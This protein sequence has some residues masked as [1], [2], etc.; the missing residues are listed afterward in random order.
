MRILAVIKPESVDKIARLRGIEELF[1]SHGGVELQID[2]T[3]AGTDGKAEIPAND[4]DHY[5]VQS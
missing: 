5:I 1:G 4:V 2:T 3:D